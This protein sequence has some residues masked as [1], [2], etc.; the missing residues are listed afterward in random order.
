MQRFYPIISIAI[1]ILVILGWV[2]LLQ[3][4]Y[5]EFGN[6]SSEIKTKE[7]AFKQK[8]DYFLRLNKTSQEL[9]NYSVEIS[10]VSQA[11]NQKIDVPALFNFIQKITSENGLILEKLGSN[12]VSAASTSEGISSFPFSISVLGSY[13]AFKNLISSFYQNIKMFE[14]ESVN[15]SS[16]GKGKQDLFEVNLN[17][18]IPYYSQ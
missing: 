1:L 3:P 15:F 8:Q 5:E 4:K 7:A 13:G 17:L 9:E 6:L 11:I 18:N 2:F 14:V 10:K 12:A 16:P